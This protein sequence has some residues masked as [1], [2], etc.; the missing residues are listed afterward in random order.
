MQYET[1]TRF[2]KDEKILYGKPKKADKVEV[3]IFTPNHPPRLRHYLSGRGNSAGMLR[4]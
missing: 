4:L 1:S 3:Y 2:E